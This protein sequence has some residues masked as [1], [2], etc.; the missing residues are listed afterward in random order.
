MAKAMENKEFHFLDAINFLFYSTKVLG[1]TP[2]SMK[3]FYQNRN[4]SISMVGNLY[5][6]ACLLFY[7]A[8][9]HFSVAA[10]YFN[11]NI[12]ESSNSKCGVMANR[13]VQLLILNCH[14][15]FALM[16]AAH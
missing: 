6:L 16:Q 15:Y 4:I 1:I 5:S 13:F 2:Y 8:L 11:G 14:F 9:H 10:M 3:E 12:F 7:I